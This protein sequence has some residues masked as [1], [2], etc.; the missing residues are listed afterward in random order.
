MSLLYFAFCHFPSFLLFFF[1]CPFF[2]CSCVCASVCVS[3]VVVKYVNTNYSSLLMKKKTFLLSCCFRTNVE[4]SVL[5]LK[6]PC[7]VVTLWFVM[8]C[9]IFTCDINFKRVSIGLFAQRKP[10]ICIYFNVRTKTDKFYSPWHSCSY[11][12]YL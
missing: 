2:Y 1:W 12:P 8:R 9:S 4:T 5:C 10:I 7:F 11:S 6:G 3:F